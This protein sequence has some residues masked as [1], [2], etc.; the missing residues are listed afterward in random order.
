MG[1]GGDVLVK[2]GG[3]SIL[4]VCWGGKKRGKGGR[5]REEIGGQKGGGC[6]DFF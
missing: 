4:E 6:F 3:L 1:G 2:R 5:E